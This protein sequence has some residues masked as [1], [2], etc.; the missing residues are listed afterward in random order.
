[1]LSTLSTIAVLFDAFGSNPN[2]R[3]LASYAY[4][5]TSKF[6][7]VLCS[8]LVGFFFIIIIFFFTNSDVSLINSN[9]FIR[10]ETVRT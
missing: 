2:K 6:P 4:I 3:L 8:V 10:D 5:L 9:I 7:S 1:M